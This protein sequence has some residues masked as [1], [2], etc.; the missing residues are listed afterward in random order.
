[1]MGRLFTIF[2]IRCKQE[3]TAEK[4]TRKRVSGIAK[5]EAAADMTFGI[6]R[7]LRC[8]ELYDAPWPGEYAQDLDDD[9]ERRQEVSGVVAKPPL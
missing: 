4:H 1:M 3:T 6:N 9:G 2:C 8:G 5:W 7:C